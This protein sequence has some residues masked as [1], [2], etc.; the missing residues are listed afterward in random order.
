MALLAILMVVAVGVGSVNL[1]PGEVWT[2]LTDA[3][4]GSKRVIVWDIRLPRVLLAALVG[5]NLAVAGALLQGV[6]RNP[7][8]DP[9]LL[10]ISAGAGVVGAFLL[11]RGVDMPQEGHVAL[12]ILGGLAGGA[13]IYL[14]AWRG[15]VSPTRL[16]LAG[17]AVSFL[18]I[19]VTT[20][21]LA[22]SGVFA[23]AS[24]SPLKLIA[25]S[26]FGRGWEHVGAIWP[27]WLVG[28]VLAFAASGMLNI[29]ALGEDVAA[30]LG[31][32]TELTR[33]AM[34]ILAVVLSGAA[35]SVAG[36][37]GFVGLVMPHVARVFVG[38]DYRY[39]IPASAL[40][41]AILLVSSDTIARN[42][43]APTELPVGV[44]TACIGA[45]FFLYLLRRIQ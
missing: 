37:I 4:A 31:L 38:Q 6:T 33:L 36:L 8:A 27:Y 26:L 30:E 25:G 19:S 5:A 42:A 43:L 22:N 20:A 32:R 24:T 23:Q 17:V 39:V 41:G 7:L 9:H 21:I 3:D 40:M 44:V 16:T 45:P 13:F 1:T 34:V 10:G 15:G 28:L 14:M 35:V 29:M 11:A 2:G 12:S 18:L